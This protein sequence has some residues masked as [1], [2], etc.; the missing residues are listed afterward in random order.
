MRNLAF[1]ICLSC[2]PIVGWGQEISQIQKDLAFLSSDLMEGRQAGSQGEQLAAVYI[3]ER[4]KEMGLSPKGDEG[5]WEQ[6]F[7]FLFSANPHLKDEDK[8]KLKARNVVGWIDKGADKTV[9]IGAHFDHIG[10][11][12]FG[13]LAPEDSAIHNGADDN[14]SGVAGLLA[15]AERLSGAEGINSNLL[16]IAFSGEE[17]G[18]FGSKY[19]AENPTVPI[20]T[21]RYMLNLDMVGRLNEEKEV[22]LSGTGTAIQWE[23]VLNEVNKDR[24]KMKFSA[25]GIGP[26]DH[27]SFYLQ[28]I[29]VIHF[30]TG[31]HAEYHKPAD[32]SHLI[33]YA[34]IELIA[35][36]ITDLVIDLEGEELSFQKTKDEKKSSPKFKVTL[37]VMPNYAYSGDGMKI[38]AVLSDRPAER[39]GLKDGDIVTKLGHMEVTDIYTYMDALAAHKKGDTVE[40]QVKRGEEMVKAQ[41]TF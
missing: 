10:Y 32:D 34:G 5:G 38:D 29:P 30:F 16:F 40:V 33:N 31:G 22:S 20:S 11:G 9:I 35:D 36:W 7:D 8:E 23:D 3:Q 28:D 6:P 25:S 21:I 12:G 24:L 18:L 13:S 41:V 1:Y 27:T 4:M 26:S 2:L 39:A 14:A 15:I 19:F 37:G 17:L